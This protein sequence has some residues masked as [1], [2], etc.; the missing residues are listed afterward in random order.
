[1][2]F[3]VP[4]F[5][6]VPVLSPEMKDNLEAV[7]RRERE[8]R[9]AERTWDKKVE[10]IVKRE[11]EYVEIKSKCFFAIEQ[12]V[13]RQILDLVKAQ[14]DYYSMKDTYDYHLL[15][16]AI[17]V[18]FTTGGV[19][20][21]NYS[22]VQLLIELFSS[23]QRDSESIPTYMERLQAKCAGIRSVGAGEYVPTDPLMAL[24][25]MLTLNSKHAEAVNTMTD[26]QFQNSAA[27]ATMRPQQ[28][29]VRTADRRDSLRMSMLGQAM[30]GGSAGGGLFSPSEETLS[31]KEEKEHTSTFPLT[32]ADMC[33]QIT[34]LTKA[35][36]SSAK[37]AKPDSAKEDKA[38]RLKDSAERK[39]EEMI[40]K[41][42][43]KTGVYAAEGG[44]TCFACEREGHL[45]SECTLLKKFKEGAKAAPSRKISVAAVGAEA[46]DD[47]DADDEDDMHCTSYA[48]FSVTAKPASPRTILAPGKSVGLEAHDMYTGESALTSAADDLNAMGLRLV[49]DGAGEHAA[50]IEREILTVKATV[51]GITRKPEEVDEFIE[52][53]PSLE[54]QVEKTVAEDRGFIELRADEIGK[55]EMTQDT[56]D[57]VYAPPPHL[58]DLDL[59]D[60]TVGRE[61]TAGNWPA[62]LKSST[63][64]KGGI[65][66]NKQSS[67]E[68]AGST[69]RGTNRL[70]N[71]HAEMSAER[72]P[73]QRTIQTSTISVTQ[74]TQIYGELA[75]AGEN[76][77]LQPLPDLDALNPMLHSNISTGGCMSRVPHLEL[78]YRS[79]Q[80]TADIMIKPLQGA[81]FR[82]H[83]HR[84]TSAAWSAAGPTCDT[85]WSGRVQE[86]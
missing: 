85:G 21:P 49:K 47:E 18:I 58:H 56:S 51:K 17:E 23:K 15:I 70:N 30:G 83:S 50:G 86:A 46:S 41:A 6:T 20:D 78:L 52:P 71:Y 10:L 57:R 43:Q 11:G 84:T 7:S 34:S 80:G 66:V 60:E 74:S 68:T 63:I 79:T 77:E 39:D 14:F 65:S 9:T 37:D 75:A 16:F 12:R 8:V 76:R 29:R 36:R 72:R 42:A 27:A 2:N 35:Q 40:A 26:F 3:T 48:V 22:A 33:W 67:G 1:M 53:W 82:R 55:S 73:A 28:G 32:M 44:R 61:I 69:S 59:D 31:G 64:L 13:D 25:L 54:H 81:A 45:I 4:P 38:R 19:T 62:A 5:P 24:L